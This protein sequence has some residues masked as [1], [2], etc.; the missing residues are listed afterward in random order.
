MYTKAV[1]YKGVWLA[2]GSQCLA[3]YQ[4]NKWKQLDELLKKID[5]DYRKLTGGAK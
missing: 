1:E 3:L 5:E 2:P 4:E